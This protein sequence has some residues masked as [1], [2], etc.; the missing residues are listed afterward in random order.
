MSAL[1]DRA[2]L[3]DDNFTQ[4][5][6]K[7]NF[8][9]RY[10]SRTVAETG[11]SHEAIWQIFQAQLI[12]RLT[13]LC[14]RELKRQQK[15]YYTIGSSGHEGNA[16]IAH[17]L[18]VDDM[19]FLH[20][21]SAAFFSARC[22]QAGHHDVIHD[23]MRSYCVSRQDP[24]ASGRHKVLGSLKYCMPPQTSTIASHLP[25]ALGA[26]MSITRAKELHHAGKLAPDSIIV[27]SFGDASVN[28]AVAQT[29][30]SS[31]Q[32]LVEQGF[33][34]PIIF[35]CED[36][37]FGISVK[38]PNHWIADLM[39]HRKGIHYIAADGLDILDT[40]AQTKVAEHYARDCHQPVFLHMKCVRLLGHAGSDIEQT[41]RDEAAIIATEAD[42][43]LLHS[44]RLLIENDI[45]DANKIL[46]TYSELKAQIWQS[47]ERAAQE[48]KL[49][50]TP[51]VMA[52]IIPQ[53]RVM[54]SQPIT[55]QQ[56][57]HV[58]GDQYPQLSLPRNM[59]QQINYALTDLMMRY[60]NALIFGEDVA[61]KGGVYHVTADLMQRFGQRRVFDTLLDETMIL[62]TAIGLA[63]NNF[64]P[65]PE[66]QFLA[67][68]HNA[69][70]QI[71]S[72]AAT[73]SFFSN[74]QFT[75]PILIRIAGF[76]YQQGFGGHFHNDNSIA[77]LRDIPGVIIAT[78]SRPDQAAK[79]LRECFRL[80]VQEQRVVIFIEPIALYMTKDFHEVGDQAWLA[81]YPMPD[82]QASYLEV[83]AN[84]ESSELAIISYANG[85]YLARQ[86]QS[87][88]AAQDY[89]VKV[90]DL[91]WLNPLPLTSLFAELRG[92]KRVLIVDECRNTGS[93]S[94]ALVT[95]LVESTEPTPS[96]KRICAADSF[97]PLGPAASCV[98]PSRDD[99]VA[100]S[101][102]LLNGE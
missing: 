100:A 73:L 60:P 66:I 5:I 11:L 48:D 75:N 8:P 98:L 79:L 86:A 32:W 28:H 30:F 90:I 78:P 39:S 57:Q 59:A 14:A 44:A 21:R 92:V 61:K 81:K 46:T 49:D 87:L 20:Y 38:T 18:R 6:S 102:A 82:K 24:I 65:I 12:S 80:V 53:E 99:I 64:I 83:E 85:Y 62:G 34:L 26:A 22:Q 56:R 68:F 3:I 93:L 35:V 84:G 94:E 71:R 97:I 77:A 74:Q 50:S 23:L 58:F 101:L 16:A 2:K 95:A 1:L 37:G 89:A 31:A 72:E 9:K 55:E 33:P 25:K 7:E 41:Y 13:D 4:N 10:S 91:Q 40:Y 47:A 52:S 15:T 88:L 19:A 42:D 54:P 96:I 69:E 51:A 70:D 63:H 76:A 27:C 29:T 43:P 45:A 17:A 36:N 67:Y